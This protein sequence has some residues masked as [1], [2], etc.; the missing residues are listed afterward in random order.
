[1]TRFQKIP[2]WADRKHVYAVVETPRGSRAK[3]KYDIKLKAFTLAKPL[4]VGLA[5]PY[6]WGF[7]PATKAEDGDPVDALIIHDAA[8]YPGLVL[9]CRPIGVL[10]IVQISRKGSERNDRVFLIPA[11]PDFEADL[12]DVRHLS[13]RMTDELQKFFQATDALDDKKLEFLGWRGPRTATSLIN[14]QAV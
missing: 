4:M 8:T 11:Q 3:L 10:E 14:K 12:Q 13:E 7:V 9:T 6:D 2:T 5:Y 1:M